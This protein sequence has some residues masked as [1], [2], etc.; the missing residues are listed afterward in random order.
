MPSDC[1]FCKISDGS[2]PAKREFENETYVVFHDIHPQAKTHLL[3]IPKRHLAT[4]NDMATVEDVELIG[5]MF[6]LAKDLAA[7]RGISGYKL[8]FNVGKDG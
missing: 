2:I 7:K 5:G 1:V 8:Q 3:I 4:V 6:L